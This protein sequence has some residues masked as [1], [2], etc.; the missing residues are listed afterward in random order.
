MCWFSA[1]PELRF[2]Q[3]SNPDVCLWS[4]THTSEEQ[5]ATTNTQ[6][7]EMGDA[8]NEGSLT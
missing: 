7:L 8:V 5:K 3:V 4:K 1:V 6:I 2:S